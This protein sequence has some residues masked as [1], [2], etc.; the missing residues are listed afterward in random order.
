MSM[1]RVYVYEGFTERTDRT[2]CHLICTIDKSQL[3]SLTYYSLFARTNY[4]PASQ[5]LPH[6]TSIS[7]SIFNQHSRLDYISLSYSYV[8][9]VT[10]FDDATA[11]RIA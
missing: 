5:L 9:Y 7:Y 3:E 6:A 4:L 8:V 10:D 11:P 2:S 1:H